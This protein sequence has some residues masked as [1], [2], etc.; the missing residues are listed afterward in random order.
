MFPPGPG[1]RGAFT[2]E[3][4]SSSSRSDEQGSYPSSR[5]A[6]A[7]ALVVDDLIL[8]RA[9]VFMLRWLLGFCR[10]LCRLRRNEPFR[11]APPEV[12]PSYETTSARRPIRWSG[13]V[14]IATK[15]F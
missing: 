4:R 11:L 6:S 5:M 8:F 15:E 10:V 14:A 1:A 2:S 3:T 7:S 9:G 12:Q 13:C